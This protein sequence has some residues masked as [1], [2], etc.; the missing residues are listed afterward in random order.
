MFIRY[1]IVTFIKKASSPHVSS[2][3]NTNEPVAVKDKPE[4]SECCL[5]TNTQSSTKNIQTTKSQAVFLTPKQNSLKTQIEDLQSIVNGLYKQRN[6]GLLGKDDKMS[7][8]KYEKKLGELQKEMKRVKK[9]QENQ[10]KFRER[11]RRKFAALDE[12]VRKKLGMQPKVGRPTVTDDNI[13]IQSITD[14]ALAGSA[15]DDRRRSE[16][17][18]TIKTLDDLHKYLQKELGISLSRSALYLRLLPRD[19]TT[20]EGKRHVTTAPVRLA[21][22]DNSLHKAHP[23][24]SF[25]KATINNIEEIASILGP[26]E[27]TFHSQDDKCRVAIGLTAAK[28]TGTIAYAHGVSRHFT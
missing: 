12:N 7:I 28:K 20:T 1:F 13:L 21:R 8:E 5:I 18:R 23:D 25:A 14:I 10:Q 17:I 6:M 22:P 15:A 24:S 26:E 9:N 4:Q 11:R 19:S 3:E 27:V 2:K 16:I